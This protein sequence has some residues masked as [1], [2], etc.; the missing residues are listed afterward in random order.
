[1]VIF[2]L[3]ATGF[4]AASASSLLPVA[5][6]A[7]QVANL[8]MIH[9]VP[10]NSLLHMWSLST[11]EQFYIVWPPVLVAL[12]HRLPRSRIAL[13]IVAV[14]LASLAW[15]TVLVLTSAPPQRILYGPDTRA[16]AILIGCLLA[17]CIHRVSSRHAAT[18]ASVGFLVLLAAV[19]LGSVDT[20]TLFPVA[21]AAAGVIAWLATTTSRAIPVWVL[22]SAPLVGLGRIS[23]GMYLWHL[24][25]AV[26]LT[27]VRPPWQVAGWT[28]AISIAIAALVWNL[29]ERPILSRA[30]PQPRP[31][32]RP[33]SASGAPLSMA[34]PREA[35]ALLGPVQGAAIAAATRPAPSQQRTDQ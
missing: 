35:A 29:V 18:W 16:D 30:K 27:G 34:A 5:I 11:E 17:L 13:T 9:G 28:V 26:A 15:R 12:L 1:L 24:P 25:L 3:C 2:L 6:S 19:P 10:M 4:L 32:T 7:G 20:W 22:S 33:T 8:A 21:M 14:G 31:R 23:Y